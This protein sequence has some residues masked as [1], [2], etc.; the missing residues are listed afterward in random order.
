MLDLG[1]DG[2]AMCMGDGAERAGRLGEVKGCTS[3]LPL[4]PYIVRVVDERVGKR[5]W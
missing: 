3:L 5:R 2:L 4:S 1:G